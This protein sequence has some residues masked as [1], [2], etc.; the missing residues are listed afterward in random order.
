AASEPARTATT[1]AMAQPRSAP[2]ARRGDLEFKSWG[3][4]LNGL[5]AEVQVP[6]LQVQKSFPL[7]SFGPTPVGPVL[8]VITGRITVR[9]SLK[10]GNPQ[11][12][13]SL[14]VG[15][16]KA[17]FEAKV[18]QSLGGISLTGGVE[19]GKASK[20]G[21]KFGTDLVEIE[22][23]AKADITK[24]FLVSLKP[25]RTLEGDFKFEE[26]T[27]EGKILPT[28]EVYFAPNPAWPGWGAVAKGTVDVTRAITVVSRGLVFAGELGVATT[29]GAVAIGVSIALAGI[30]WIGLGL[31]LIGKA[32]RDGRALALGFTFNRGYAS[33]LA[34]LTS[35]IALYPD[36]PGGQQ[37]YWYRLTYDW[38][39]TLEVYRARWLDNE[40][41]NALGK[42]S[43]LGSIAALQDMALFLQIYGPGKW[44][45]LAADHRQKYGQAEGFRA[46]KYQNIMNRQ[47]RAGKTVGIPL[48]PVR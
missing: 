16:Q 11:S 29:V 9:G 25:K 17:D 30:A 42:V 18:Y 5:Q 32:H 37:K 23:A 6:K 38:R 12:V 34:R 46:E 3:P 43:E 35:G 1:V 14:S 41:R 45:E 40:D 15:E 27:F 48:V 33:T 31:Y 8:V 19:P 39:G 36:T 4:E 7:P 47:L 26:W 24:P 2:G 28:L 10:H 20:I 22:F 21:V 13:V 44:K